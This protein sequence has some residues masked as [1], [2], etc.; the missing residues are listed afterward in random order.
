MSK[1]AYDFYV[2]SFKKK[3]TATHWIKLSPIVQENLVPIDEPA[4]RYSRSVLCEKSADSSEYTLD[5]LFDRVGVF[6]PNISCVIHKKSTSRNIS[7][8]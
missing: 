2:N 5:S 6:Y 1:Y 7:R 4:L 8:L 3:K